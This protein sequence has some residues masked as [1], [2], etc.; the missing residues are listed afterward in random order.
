MDPKYVAQ[1]AQL[2]MLLEV[3]SSPKPGNIDR[4]HD[5]EDTRYEHFLASA[6]AV[7]PVFEEAS[8]SES[9]VGKLVREAVEESN[10]WQS[11]GNTSFGT[12]LMLI[13]LIM[14]AGQSEGYEEV[15]EKA[16][17][18]MRETTSQDAVDLYKAFGDTDIKVKV[19][20]DL[21]VNNPS[22]IEKIRGEDL[23]FYRIMSISAPY[24]L[25]SRELTGGFERSFKYASEIKKRAREMSTNDSIVYTYLKALS[26]EPD[27]FIAVKFGEEKA[28][29]ISKEALEVL[30][31]TGEEKIR[32]FDERLIRDKIN[33]G[34]TADI[35]VAAIFLALL[36]GLQL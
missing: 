13:P 32:E 29:S 17:Q 6:V 15:K 2:A 7:F 3:S 20:S 4:D 24:D 14:A 36:D 35:I 11:G 34:S 5:Y 25:I 21:D 30:D 16:D 18:I 33:P 9:G 31:G 1:L 8:Q 19:V 26:E 10:R 28:I 23:T 12:F 27:T 22:S